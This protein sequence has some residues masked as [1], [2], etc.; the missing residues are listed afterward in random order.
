M[1][2]SLVELMITIA[3][4]AILVALAFPS[5]EDS[6]RNNRV[7]STTNELIASLSLARM[8]ALR[9]PGGAFICT[10]SDGAT[11][12]GS[13]GSWNDGWIVWIDANGDG[14]PGGANDRVLR[15]VE[16]KHRLDVSAASPGGATFANRIRFDNR[17][18]VDTHTRQIEVQPDTC[19][20]GRQLVSEINIALTGQA[21]SSK[22]ACT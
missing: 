14:N 12:S 16:G 11:C 17:G 21:R 7:T 4:V 5:F 18:R 9:N 8:E 3:I 19:P 13:G 1:G 10:S 15:Y 22:K 6:L 2:F 20:T